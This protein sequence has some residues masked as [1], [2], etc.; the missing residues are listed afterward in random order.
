VA[1]STIDAIPPEKYGATRVESIPEWYCTGT[2]CYRARPVF[3]LPHRVLLSLP[4]LRRETWMRYRLPLDETPLC[5]EDV[6][7]TPVDEDLVERLRRHPEG[8]GDQLQ[9][10]LRFW[11]S[12]FGDGFAWCEQ[13]QPLCIIWL[14]T[15]RHNPARAR[16]GSWAG[17][18]PALASGV[19]VIEG[20]YT[21]RRGLRRRGGAATSMALATFRRAKDMGLRELRTH[22]HHD[23]LAAQRWAARVGWRPF[24]AIH[25]YSLDLRGLR[26]RYLYVHESARMHDTSPA[27][28]EKP[29]FNTENT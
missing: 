18:Y 29:Q 20:I 2:R 19:G 22:I 25:R 21:F 8:E 16:L 6:P 7:L 4:R 1:S 15:E 3:H 26:G 13:E 9:S 14:V 5:G 12:G 24:G 28:C 23:N 10:A 11:H 17:M 27:V